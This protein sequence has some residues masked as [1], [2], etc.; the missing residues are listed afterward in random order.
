MDWC[1]SQERIDPERLVFLDEMGLQTD[2]TRLRGWA[3]TGERLVEAVPGGKWH[4]STL[5]QAIGLDGIRAAMLLDGPINASSFAGFC[6]WLLIPALYPGDIVVLD[7]LSSHRSAAAI[8]A[9]E[10]GGARVVYLPPYSPDLNPIENVF[11]KVKQLFRKIRPR[12]FRQIVAAAKHVL[13]KITLD[14]LESVFL[15]CG[16]IGT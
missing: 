4:T 8:G 2:L 11:S 10:A 13:N 5:V 9:I 6:R 1:A 14:D 15:H 3:P 7:N 16:Y 12:N